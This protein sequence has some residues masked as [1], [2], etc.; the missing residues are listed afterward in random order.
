M[1]AW[2]YLRTQQTARDIGLATLNWPVV[3]MARPPLPKY[4]LDD[5]LDDIS[6]PSTSLS[7]NDSS[8]LSSN[9]NSGTRLSSRTVSSSSGPSTTPLH[10]PSPSSSL[11][12]R[13]GSRLKP[14]RNGDTPLQPPAKLNTRGLSSEDDSAYALPSLQQL[15]P[16]RP[17]RAGGDSGNDTPVAASK[18]KKAPKRS[19]AVMTLREQEKV[20]LLPLLYITLGMLT[21]SDAPVDCRR[22]R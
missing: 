11:I 2:R 9:L 17:T 15:T 4:D 10:T 22:S 19:N 18:D 20:R 14:A 6:L 12:M 7:L 3:P 5:S 8:L 21:T 16:R 1:D 13:S